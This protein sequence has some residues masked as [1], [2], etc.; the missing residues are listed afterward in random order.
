MGSEDW[1]VEADKVCESLFVFVLAYKH[2]YVL[3][4]VTPR[5]LGESR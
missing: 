1:I 4:W 2:I 5:H 3:L